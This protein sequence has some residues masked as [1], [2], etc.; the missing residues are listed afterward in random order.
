MKEYAEKLKKD[1]GHMT[2]TTV[3]SK[4]Q[5]GRNNNNSNNKI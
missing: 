2:R 1:S 4:A 3:K 5:S